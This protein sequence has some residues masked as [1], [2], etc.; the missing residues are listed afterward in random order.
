MTIKDL[1]LMNEAERILWFANAKSSDLTLVLKNE[2]IRLISK[3][4]KADKL[5]I[6]VGMVVENKVTDEDIEKVMEDT[7]KLNEEINVRQSFKEKIEGTLYARW[8]AKEITW[9]EFKNTIRNYNI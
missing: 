4:K 6:V 5:A 8:K 3:I 7:K 9:E 1:K 2:G